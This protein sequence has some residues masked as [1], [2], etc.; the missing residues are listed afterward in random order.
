MMCQHRGWM[1]GFVRHTPTFSGL[2][3]LVFE[4]RL[5]ECSE[6]RAQDT[7]VIAKYVPQRRRE[8]FDP[9]PNRDRPEN[10]VHQ[11]SPT[12]TLTI[13]QAEAAEPAAPATPRE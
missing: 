6:P 8:A 11:M 4:H 5:R 3:H 13:S 2:L 10:A 1:N 9:M 12:F 7:V